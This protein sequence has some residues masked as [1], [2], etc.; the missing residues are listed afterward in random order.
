MPTKDN[1]CADDTTQNISDDVLSF[2]TSFASKMDEN[3]LWPSE[4][5]DDDAPRPSSAT[6]KQSPPSP[7]I[8]GAKAKAAPPMPLHPPGYTVPLA[9]TTAQVSSSGGFL[10]ATSSSS[11]KFAPGLPLAAQQDLS[12]TTP[13]KLVCNPSE[14]KKF[15]YGTPSKVPSPE[16]ASK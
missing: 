8:P 13:V 2:L 5:E 15:L 16:Q 14:M 7:Q 6:A 12:G 9:P 3:N 1:K 4:E 11:S 10:C